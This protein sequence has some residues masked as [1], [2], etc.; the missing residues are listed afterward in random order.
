LY[1]YSLISAD[2]R[3]APP[4]GRGLLKYARGYQYLT[5]SLHRPCVDVI[6]EVR[7]RARGAGAPAQGGA[8]YGDAAS[9]HR[10]AG[11]TR[12]A[13]RRPLPLPSRRPRP[14]LPRAAGTPGLSGAAYGGAASGHQ[15]VGAARDAL[16][17]RLRVRPQ[18]FLVPWFYPPIL[19]CS[20]ISADPMA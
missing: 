9:G 12:D 19:I 15:V 8:A 20:V 14:R 10:A 17:L 1:I 13:L 3:E 4:C 5:S 6:R 7:L 18:W 11:A 2:S 16:R